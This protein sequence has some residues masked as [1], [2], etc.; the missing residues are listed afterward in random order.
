MRQP[1][2]TV[3]YPVTDL[4]RA[5][6]VYSALLGHAPDMDQPYYVGYTIG[7]QHL[8]LDPNGHAHGLTTSVNYVDVV[9]ID[10]AIRTLTTSGAAIH[11]PPADVGGGKVIAVLKDP[12]GNLFGLS[13]SPH[14]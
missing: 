9:D 7:D 1:I 5:K 13:Q 4:A 8:G 3:V 11:Q 6:G 12:D 14:A 10:A 2:K